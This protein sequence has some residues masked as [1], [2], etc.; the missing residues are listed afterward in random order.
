MGPFSCLRTVGIGL[1]RG[2]RTGGIGLRRGRRTG[3]IGLRRGRRTGG[4]GRERHRSDTT[5][6]E[7]R[8]D[9]G[10]GL[11]ECWRSPTYAAL[12]GVEPE[13]IP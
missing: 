4:R 11:G 5:R 8:T 10:A 9:S 12:T 2:R 6:V 3:G 13:E 7:R 1:R